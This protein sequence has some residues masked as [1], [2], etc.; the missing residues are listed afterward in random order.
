MSRSR[1]TMSSRTQ[2]G[3]TRGSAQK[4]SGNAVPVMPRCLGK[5]G[6]TIK[7]SRW[8]L[9]HARANTKLALLGSLN[10]VHSGARP[11]CYNL[12]TWRRRVHVQAGGPSPQ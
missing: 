7:G 10:I 3:H 6:Y 5:T 11:W 1:Q 9:S 2:A 12:L 8:N 4:G